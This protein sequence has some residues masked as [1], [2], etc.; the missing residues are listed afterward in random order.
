MFLK[1]PLFWL[2]FVSVVICLIGVIKIFAIIAPP[3][4]YVNVLHVEGANL[5]IEFARAFNL[6]LDAGQEALGIQ[7]KAEVIY[8]FAF[9]FLISSSFTVSG[10]SLFLRKPWARIMLLSLIILDFLN[11]FAIMFFRGKFTIK[12]MAIDLLIFYIFLLIFFTRK[13]IIQLFTKN[14]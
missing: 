4:L 8:L 9:S 5:F 6:Y 14:A 11:N 13:P 7:N 10:V 2:R 1:Q 3:T 12:F